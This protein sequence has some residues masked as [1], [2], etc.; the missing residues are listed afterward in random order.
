MRYGLLIASIAVLT[1]CTEMA[2]QPSP[3]PLEEPD[4]A[5]PVS[6][7]LEAL[8]ELTTELNAAHQQHVETCM[9][10]RG[11]G[12]LTKAQSLAVNRKALG[13]RE[14]LTFDP[15]EAGPYTVEQARHHGMQGTSALFEDGDVG[16]VVSKDPRFDS[17]LT[18][19]RASFADNRGV[20]VDD[21]LSTSADLRNRMRREFL[22]AARPAI[23]ALLDERTACV[24]VNGYPTLTGDLD[25]SMPDMLASAGVQVDTAEAAAPPEPEVAPGTVAVFPPPE[26]TPHQPSEA[27]TALALVYVRCGHQQDW[28]NRWATAQEQPREAVLKA[29]QKEL[30]QLGTE[31]HDLLETAHRDS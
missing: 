14:T 8:T 27:E 2:S 7:T 18:A 29:H 4:T 17:A 12:Q 26:R 9:Q 19:C 24:R 22:A 21:A 31:A 28:V 13:D 15:L 6:Y 20:Q 10:E 3:S 1:G 11:Y 5:R 30:N 23:E 16:Y 25:A